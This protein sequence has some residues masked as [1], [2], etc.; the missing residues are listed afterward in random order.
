MSEFEDA[1]VLPSDMRAGATGEL[2][3]TLKAARGTAVVLDGVDVER[4]DT[5]TAQLFA[6]AAKSWAQDEQDFSIYRPSEKMSATL[7]R[8]GL[9]D[10]VAIKD[11]GHVN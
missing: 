1:I 11:G 8:L 6:I 7:S 3:D 9:Q 10:V 2:F 5:L 4:M